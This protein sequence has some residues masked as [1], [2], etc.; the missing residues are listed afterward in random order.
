[1]LVECRIEKK[2]LQIKLEATPAS[3]YGEL[4][5]MT[6]TLHFFVHILRVFRVEHNVF[7]L[8]NSF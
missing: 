4:S 1:M 5:L 3:K 6:E 7:I 2:E 8:C